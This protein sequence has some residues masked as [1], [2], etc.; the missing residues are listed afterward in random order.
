MKTWKTVRWIAIALSIITW[1]WS[2]WPSEKVESVFFASKPTELMETKN[3]CDS[4]G[5][6]FNSSFDVRYPKNLR[7]FEQDFL[8][9]T[10]NPGQPNLKLH[11]DNC[12]VVLEAFLDISDVDIKPGPRIINP[13]SA[14]S[15]QMISFQI[16][17]DRRTESIEGNLW[18][19]AN[20]TDKLEATYTEKR[21][22][23]FVIPIQIELIDVLG[24]PFQVL[25]LILMSVALLLIF[26][27]GI[28]KFLK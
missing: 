15:H 21:I 20:M 5:Q 23:L 9:L 27:P 16:T 12:A 18:I 19:H 3:D 8:A 1:A 26:G 25:R 14:N 28:M 13:I 22:P 10:I 7:Y 11:E 24:I 4:L 17:A 2:I 6:L